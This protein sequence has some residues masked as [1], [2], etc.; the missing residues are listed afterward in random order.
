MAELRRPGG[1]APAG[2]EVEELLAEYEPEKPARRLSGPPK[3]LVS[4]AGV[5]LSCYAILWVLDPQP[6]QRYRMTFLAVALGMTFLVYRPWPRR[7]APQRPPAAAPDGD[8]DQAERPDNPGVL[9]WALAVAA[10]AAIALPLLDFDDFVRRAV[11]PTATDVALGVA[12]ILLVLEATRRTV[13]WVL[14]AVC[15]VF[16]AYA[17]Y[18]NLIPVGYSLGHVGY[19]VDRLVGQTFM[20]VEGIFGVPLDV[21]ATYIVLFTI[22]GAV[23]EYSGAGRYFI[24]VSFAA[25]GTSAAAPARTVTLAGFLLGTV[26]GSGVATTVTLGSV[27]W[28]V[29]HRAGYPRDQG[30]GVLAAA[31]IGAILSP[32][33]LGA[34]AFI[35]AEFLNVSYLQVLLF[36]T[37]PTALYYLGV[38]L[39]IEAD[40][41]RLRTRAVAVDTPPLGRLLWR[42]GYHF[43]SLFL[44]V[45]LMALGLSP[46]RA[47]LYATVA[48]FL[49]SFLD[50][51][52]AMT[53][54]RVWDALAA[55]ATGVLPVAATTAAAGIIVAVVTLTGLGLKV[56]S[57]IVDLAG[58]RLLL[59]TLYSAV[60][61][62]VLGLAVP[63]TA[64][65]IIA[66]VIIGPAL[67][68]LGVEPFAA[69]MFI[70]YYAVL[71]EVSPPTALSAVAAAAITGGNPFRTMLLT[72]RYTLP[73]FLVP[74]AFVLSPRGEALLLQ[75]PAVDVLLAVAVS[76]VAVAALAVATGGWL[77]GPAGR[78]ERVLAGLAALP[79][80]YLEPRTIA[81]GLA[82]AA[83]A[84]AVHLLARRRRAA[85][86]PAA[87]AANRDTT[88]PSR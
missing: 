55:G 14:P 83:A 65:F 19:D 76:A 51:S 88:T 43:S 24:D 74:F 17:Y 68:S 35:I 44:I 84:V 7:R 20:G 30:G 28:P 36:A 75:G 71:S 78:P 54:R 50:R 34:A 39:A 85:A 70:F 52:T 64:S 80:L 31:G 57:I 47:V 4:A 32:P 33:T 21:A 66:A 69:Y 87:T 59:A 81:A 25:F 49:L 72:W 79:L 40:S 29:L 2:G 26:S 41:R 63:V 60:A 58:G 3:L 16:L 82:M 1:V 48:A 8:H 42:W 23:L 37:I 67:T 38:V 46:F 86:P 5:A 10:V 77:A 15:L 61:V 56:S 27:A 12:A 62:L 9:D 13:G 11:R 53:P 45:V 18:G 6:A 22:Y 73:A